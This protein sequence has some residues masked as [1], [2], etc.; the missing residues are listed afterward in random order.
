MPLDTA[1]VPLR[2]NAGRAATRR[3]IARIDG[4]LRIAKHVKRLVAGYSE[5]LGALAADPVIA[6]DLLRLS[7]HEALA[8]DLRGRALNHEPVDYAVL[9]QHERAV[10]R[11]RTA[12]SLD[13]L[14]EP[15]PPPTLGDLERRY[16]RK[17][18][19]AS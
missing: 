3:R 5:R 8:A 19:A 9:N 13:R 12:L 6:A 10:R 17:H 1:S 15:P 4:R 14:P 2:S 11:L 7:E 16:K 18:E